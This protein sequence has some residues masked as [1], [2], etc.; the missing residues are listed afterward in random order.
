MDPGAD[1]PLIQ[2]Q[3]T[4]ID[5]L[6]ARLYRLTGGQGFRRTKASAERVKTQGH[7]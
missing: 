5:I 1:L 6:Y 4:L 7:P 3:L 2:G